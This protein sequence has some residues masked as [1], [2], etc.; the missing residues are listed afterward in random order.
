MVDGWQ[1]SEMQSGHVQEELP[2]PWVREFTPDGQAYYV[3]HETRTTQWER[4]GFLPPPQTSPIMYSSTSI[5]SLY[6]AGDAMA[7][8]GTTST[9]MNSILPSNDIHNPP[10][11]QGQATNQQGRNQ[12]SLDDTAEA[13]NSGVFS[14]NS[15]KASIMSFTQPAY[16]LEIDRNVQV[17]KYNQNGN[18]YI[19]FQDTQANLASNEHVKKQV[20][21][22]CSR[23]ELEESYGK[24]VIQYFNFLNFV[25]VSNV[26]L[27]AFSL[28]GFIPHVKNASPKLSDSGFGFLNTSTISSLDLLFLSTFQ[29][30]T[31]GAWVSMMVLVTIF[32]FLIGPMYFYTSTLFFRDYVKNAEA[33][34]SA[35]DDKISYD[36]LEKEVSFGFK[37]RMIISYAVFVLMCACPLAIMYAVL[38]QMLYR[39]IPDQYNSGLKSVG[40]FKEGVQL[41]VSLITS[42]IVP[43]SN[44]IFDSIV[45]FLTDLE[46][47]PTW[48]SYRRHRLLKIV[49]F[50]LVN[51][52]GL[53]IFRFYAD[54]P[55][56]TCSSSRIAFQ[57]FIF[58]LMDITINNFVE[59]FW[60]HIWKLIVCLLSP[61]ISL[62]NKEG[63]DEEQKPEF[64]L[65]DEYF[66]IVYRQFIMYIGISVFPMITG[67]TLLTNIVEWPIDRYRLIYH[68]RRPRGMLVGGRSMLSKLLFFSALCSIIA[69]PSGIVWFG[70]P[71]GPYLC[72][73]C[74]QYSNRA[75]S[76]SVSCGS[77]FEQVQCSVGGTEI[78]YPE[79]RTN[80]LQLQS[81]KSSPTQRAN[82][83]SFMKQ[84][85][86]S[87][88]SSR[89]CACRPCVNVISCSCNEPQLYGY[90]NQIPDYVCPGTGI[91]CTRGTSCA[92][93]KTCMENV[94]YKIMQCSRSIRDYG[95][96]LQNG[97]SKLPPTCQASGKSCSTHAD[98]N[99][100]NGDFCQG[101]GAF[102]CP[103][104]EG[105]AAANFSHNQECWLCPEYLTSGLVNP[106]L[107]QDLW[108]AL[109]DD[110]SFNLCQKCFSPFGRTSCNSF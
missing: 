34:T 29:P 90:C 10:D 41:A 56:Y 97:T 24:P 54:L 48:S 7:R 15:I 73:P 44:L 23:D 26:I 52:Y 57:I 92:D 13:N 46:K 50:R 109:N 14:L 53:F 76:P 61:C 17:L 5:R 30:S 35:D 98:C 39:T 43:I 42:A 3:N 12:N 71:L 82:A 33:S 65:T 60:P 84:Y 72:W 88:Q 64:E 69:F 4:P 106:K 20:S 80:L 22:F 8:P 40:A 108:K 28:I 1:P 93:G 95:I 38:F 6:P 94:A 16:E 36:G 100:T 45:R 18:P 85:F 25:I 21:F 102:F 104:P 96:L 19:A 78:S 77:Q 9:L 70:P 2:Y 47:H 87:L 62:E 37:Q 89:R 11:S 74:P 91:P 49:L 51:V 81:W 99:I 59:F 66:E 86:G 63:S 55:F 110:S 83:V 31:D 101:G 58:I 75:I 107:T 68:C 103:N 105:F 67:I 27:F 79:I 32:M